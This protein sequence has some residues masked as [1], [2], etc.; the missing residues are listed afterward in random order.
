MPIPT[1]TKG[2]DRAEFIDRCMK[3]EVMV[4]EYDDGQRRA[5]CEV[6]ADYLDGE[7]R[8]PR[9]ATGASK[10]SFRVAFY[11]SGKKTRKG[12]A[13]DVV[14]G[15]IEGVSLIQLGEAKGHGIYVDGL[16]LGSALEVLGSVNLP[17]FITHA[18]ALQDDRML[19]QVGYFSG[20]YID[21]GKLKAQVFQSL[22]SFRDDEAE[23]FNRL[24]D[25]AREMPDAFGLSLVFEAELVWVFKNGEEKSVAESEGKP[26]G[27]VREMPSVRFNSISS[28]D[29][30]DEPAANEDGLF[31]KKRTKLQKIME[32]DEN[33]NEE[34]A[35][36]V[37]LAE[38]EKDPAE[39]IDQD[40][41]EPEVT[42]EEEAEE[43]VEK[44]DELSALRNEVEALKAELA[45]LAEKLTSKTDEAAQ[46][47]KQLDGE[48]MALAI[49]PTA[50]SVQSIVSKFNAATGGEQTRIWK[51]NKQTILSA[52]TKAS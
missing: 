15:A 1:P 12:Y 22:E 44:E 14:A 32:E 21:Q 24:F 5:I 7:M 50:E 45:Q 51:Q 29:F 6:Q 28:A 23:S 31:S 10:N 46:L 30:V 42:T 16:S 47:S 20:F 11:K 17:A 41:N 9:N 35:K 37:A 39:E 48:E 33:Q 19:K 43:E 25:L 4:V 36:A 40:E 49:Q 18:G 13:V 52:L 2:E 34:E 27:A 26:A 3:D 38:P 8:L